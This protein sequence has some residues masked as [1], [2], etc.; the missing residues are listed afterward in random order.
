MQKRSPFR[1][2][3]RK[4][5]SPNQNQR[6]STPSPAYWSGFTQARLKVQAAPSG[7][8]VAPSHSAALMP[9]P[10]GLPPEPGAAMRIF[11]FQAWRSSIISRLLP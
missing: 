5:C 2:S 8:M 10:V 3:F 11:W 9:D 6:P 1:F 4:G 7:S